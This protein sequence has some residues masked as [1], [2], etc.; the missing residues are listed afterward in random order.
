[1]IDGG[2]GSDAVSYAGRT[3][4]V[5]VDLTLDGP[6]QGGPREGDDARSIERVA[7]G[8]GADTL[9]GDEH[10]NDLAGGPGDDV[11]VGGAGADTLRPGRGANGTDGGDG[12]DRIVVWGAETMGAT[13]IRCGSG[14]DFYWGELTRTVTLPGVLLRT[15]CEG[16][17]DLPARP[18]SRRTPSS[19]A[20]PA[21]RASST[22]PTTPATPGC[23]LAVGRR[24]LGERS[25]TARNDGRRTLS[26]PRTGA[27]ARA[28]RRHTPLRIELAGYR[29]VES[30]FGKDER[31]TLV[32]RITL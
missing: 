25:F 1:V 6:V 20:C 27:L 15:D 32:W 8:D 18:A 30:D 23:G 3:T 4:P 16:Y 13:T 5:T 26:F 10:R 28:I 24:V 17:G 9:A 22:T 12:N 19:S 14:E 21:S 7:G 31:G 2:G 29:E 11:I